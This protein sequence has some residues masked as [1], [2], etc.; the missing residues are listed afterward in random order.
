MS[1][2]RQKKL[3]KE[4]VKNLERE[5][6]L[7]SGELVL[8]SGYSENTATRQIPAVFEQKGVVEELAKLGFD[9]NNAKRVVGEILNNSEDQHRLK[10]A[11]MIFKVGGDYAPEKKDIT[12]Q[13]EKIGLTADKIAEINELALDE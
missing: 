3:A 12:T 9:S 7:N 11:D 2:Q 13:G 4:I 5:K 8:S 6:P 1:T 10:A